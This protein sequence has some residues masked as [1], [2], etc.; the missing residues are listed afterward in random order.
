MFGEDPGVD[1]SQ[2]PTQK[3]CVWPLRLEKSPDYE[4]SHPRSLLIHSASLECLQSAIVTIAKSYHLTIFILELFFFLNLHII[5]VET[6]MV[7]FRNCKIPDLDVILPAFIVGR[8]CLN[9][10][11]W[12]PDFRHDLCQD[13][14]QAWRVRLDFTQRLN[15]VLHQTVTDMVHDQHIM[16]KAL[17]SFTESTI[18]KTFKCKI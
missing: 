18:S 15:D 12:L 1:F 2:L 8:S 9:C 11:D 4:Q 5:C 10:C 13:W 17:Y 6:V 16:E 3:C 7:F 14:H